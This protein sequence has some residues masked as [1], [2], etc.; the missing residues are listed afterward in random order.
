M[1]FLNPWL[2]LGLAG[3]LVPIILHMMRR[4]AAQPLDWGAMRFLFDTVAMRRRR[5]EWEDMLLMAA[6]CLL[7]ALLALAVAR[8]F[9]PPDST[10]PWGVVLPLVLLGVAVAG[11]SVV[12]TRALV[13]WITLGV[14]LLCFLAAVLLVLWER[15]LN[16]ERFQNTGSRDI[17]LVIDG[18]TS[19]NIPRADG[20][21]AFEWAVEEAIQLVKE[22]P[23][24]SAFSVVLGGPAPEEKTGSPLTHRADVIEVLEELEPVGGPFQAHDALGVSLLNLSR[25]YHGAKE[26]VVFTDGQRLG[27]RLDSPS[28]WRSFGEALEGLPRPPKLLV[29]SFPSPEALRNVAVS[30]IELSREVVGTDREVTI[31]IT[32]ENTGTEAVTPEPLQLTVGEKVL[33]PVGVGQLAPGQEETVEV[34]HLFERAGPVVV[35][36]RLDARDDLR[37]DDRHEVVVAVRERLPV[38]L[39]DGNPSSGFFE[40]AAGFTALALAPSGSLVS[41]G[42]QEEEA[43][44]MEPTVVDAPQVAGVDDLESYRVVVLADVVRLPTRTAERIASFVA[45]GGGLLILAGPRADGGFYNGWVGPDGSVTP[46]DLGPLEALDDVLRPAPSTFDHESLV[47]F[48]D[49]RASDLGEA[50]FSGVRQVTGIRE[51]AAVAARFSNGEP[52]LAGK[53]Y[54]KGRVLVAA[55]AFDSRTGNL[56]TRRSF[57]P[58]VHEVVTWLAGAGGIDLNVEASWSPALALPGAG[59]LLGTYYRSDDPRRGV[60]LQRVDPGI[61]FTWGTE[62]PYQGMNRDNFEVHWNGHLVPPMSGAYRFILQVDDK[63]TLRLDD[64][65]ILRAQGRGESQAVELEAGVAVP[66]SIVFEEEY[67]EALIA[68][69]WRLPGGA[70]ELIPARALIPVQEER[71]STVVDE[72]EAVDPRGV[73]RGMKLAVGR[74]GRVLEL[75]GAAIPGVYKL[76]VPEQLRA[77]IE[78]FRAPEVPMVV[79]RDIRESRMVGLS[80]DDR[81]LIRSNIDLVEA[82]S[83]SDLLAILDGRGFGQELWKI[84]AVAAFLLLLLE[85]ALARWIS[86][87]RRTAEEVKVE[88][89]ERGGPDAALLERMDKLKKVGS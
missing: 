41:G 88:F 59:G 85:V 62:A 47:L 6:R 4:Q 23:R 10:I 32:V 14:G 80:D 9:V 18:S 25:G 52:F 42:D 51:G 64:E 7:I 33:E 24:G 54:G 81:D 35:E 70:E 77:E 73:R 46:L 29:R 40:R 1:L 27:W 56:T 19:M 20:R 39:V 83:V 48:K 89:E 72:G 43:Y 15:H 13:R 30:N 61:Q 49:D 67:G 50:A 38:L 71:A 8:P 16:L 79:R 26:I 11:A 3:V 17:A 75:E 12:L 57:V 65:V 76:E 74:R 86:Q 69:S 5:M 31:R 34:R 60:A 44:L 45:N 2:L 87:S 37:E 63:A 55:S 36:A 78:E 68:L 66:L 58:L 28:A 53:N 84:L 82:R 22:A 21:S